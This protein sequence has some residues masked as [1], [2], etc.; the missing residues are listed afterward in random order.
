MK[1]A[2][3]KHLK[4]TTDAE[5]TGS[6][7]KT[8]PGNDQPS[9]WP[10]PV[11]TTSTNRG[12]IV[13]LKWLLRVTLNKLESS[14]LVYLIYGSVLTPGAYFCNNNLT[15]T[16]CELLYLYLVYLYKGVNTAPPS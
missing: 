6:E 14:V 13:S 1:N 11:S 7:N 10:Q 4:H 12:C 8:F 15:D 2:W 3:K 16:W 5:E 9:I